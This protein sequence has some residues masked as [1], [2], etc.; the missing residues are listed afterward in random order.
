MVISQL[1]NWLEFFFL[2]TTQLEYTKKF[3]N[4][5]CGELFY[6]EKF[7]PGADLMVIYTNMLSQVINFALYFHALYTLCGNAFYSEHSATN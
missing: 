3:S 2:L 5:T 7:P 4:L 6:Q 1:L